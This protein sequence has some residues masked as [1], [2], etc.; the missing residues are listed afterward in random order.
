[1][2]RNDFALAV[3][4]V[5]SRLWPEAG[6]ELAHGSCFQLLV[7][8]ILSAQ[9]TDEQVNKVTPQLFLRYPDAGSMMDAPVLSIESIIRSTGFYHTK[10]ANIKAASRMLVSLYNDRVPDSIEELIKLPGV[11]R[12]T[13]NLVVSM[14]YGKPGLVV[15][16]HVKRICKRLGLSSSDDPNIIERHLGESIAEQYWTRFSFALNRHG[17]FVCKA[18]KPLCRICDLAGIC[19]SAA[20]FLSQMDA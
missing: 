13:A 18:R 14:C 1:M 4:E 12:K 7:S 19:P 20:M 10:A 6:T 9:C 15:D 16:T 5:V 2:N 17:K 3:Y 11:G 8:V